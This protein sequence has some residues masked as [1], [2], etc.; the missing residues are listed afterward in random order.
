MKI[1]SGPLAI[2]GGSLLFGVATW[3]LPSLAA[4]MLSGAVGFGV[5]EVVGAALMT[6]RLVANS[7]AGG[8]AMSRGGA[9][10]GGIA[11]LGAQQSGGGVMGAIKGLGTAGGALGREAMH[12]AVPRLGRGVQNLQQQRDKWEGRIHEQTAGRTRT[13]AGWGKAS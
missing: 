5:Q 2:A 9:A 7:V 4:S 13:P 11:K 3:L 8:A 1:A 12:A 10:A 6:S